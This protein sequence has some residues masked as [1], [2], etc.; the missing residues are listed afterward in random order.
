MDFRKK[1]MVYNHQKIEKK[2]QKIWEKEKI[3]EPNFKKPRGKGKFY[4]LMMFPYPSAEGLHVGN[5]YAFVGSDIYGRYQR[6]KGFD[7][8]EPIGLDGFGIHSEN[9]AIKIGTHPMKQAKVSERNFYRQLK[10][11]GNSFAWNECLETYSPE[12]YKWTQWIFI[13]MFKK[14]LAYRKK[15]AVNWCPSCKTV[16]AN[17]QVVS[18]RCERC[19][20]EVIKKELE[21]WFFKIT[22]YAERLLKNLNKIDW[23]EKIKIAQKNWIGQS[24]G[25]EIE[26]RIKNYEL[27]IKIF[28]TRLD[29]IFG[30]TYLVIAPEHLILRNNELGIRNYETVK[31]Y[32]EQ[33]KKKSDLQRTDLAK[34]KTGVELKG[35]KAIN[36]FNNEALPI[37]VADYVLGQYGTGA[38]MAVPAHDERDFEFAKK[39]NL[40]I[41]QVIYGSLTSIGSLTSQTLKQSFEDDGV[42]VNSRQ[43]TGLT[44]EKAREKMT[45]W[46]VENKLGSKKVNYKL[47]DW[48]I[49]RQR[50]WGPPIP[51]V[52][53]KKCDWQ[54]VPERDLP[55]LLPYVKNFRP[56]GTDKSPLASVE[57]FYKTKCPKCKGEAKRETDVSDT[58]LDSAWYYLRYPSVGE[59]RSVFNEKIIKKWL[60]LDMY[61][62]GSEHAVLHLLYVRF[63]AMVFYDLKLINFEEP[64][65][66]FRAHGLIIKDGA[67]M[68]KSKGNVVNPDKYV[69]NFGADALRMYLMFLGPFEM[70]GDFRDEGIIGIIRFLNR[71]WALSQKKKANISGNE[72]L[73]HR[74]I[75]KVSEDME[76]LSYNTT[77]SFLMVLLRDL[78]EKC[79]VGQFKTFLKLL[80]PFAPFLTEEIWSDLVSDSDNGRSKSIH[81]QSWPKYNPKLII[82]EQFELVIQINGKIKDK[83]L[84]EIGVSQKKAENLA[85]NQEKIKSAISGQ[86]IRKIIFVP[87]KLIN[88]V[89]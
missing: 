55:V 34:D 2:W 82:E 71:V 88:I 10:M 51:M 50:Y 20:V 9:Y 73:I 17:E 69:K 81:M 6:M 89:L 42:L 43:F 26:F 58:F 27:G 38:V 48:L 72:K 76:K 1:K 32:I 8:F 79:S 28:T 13:Q 75:K 53:C 70:G 4:N 49:S 14:G 21:Q 78:E 63:L 23:S 59:K 57:K 22:D 33:S 29:T 80:A 11:I 24:E 86:K 18:G 47:R 19:S 54:P 65:K 62:G 12:Y 64:A 37:F 67:K 84:A 39:Y 31:K 83:I 77:I 15:Q 56:T 60:P 66:K 41:K 40:P 45:E 30:C 46:L 61:I 74:T 52:Y 36:P 44:S 68:S 16:L 5:I 7:V 25:A 3:F 35:I 85:L 87:N